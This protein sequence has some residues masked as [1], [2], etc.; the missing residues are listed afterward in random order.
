[1]TSVASPIP[2]YFFGNFEPDIVYDWRPSLVT[3]IWNDSSLTD[4]ASHLVTSGERW[5]AA[6]GTAPD[7]SWLQNDL[8]SMFQG[9]R[10]L[11]IRFLE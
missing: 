10:Q 4:G 5:R 3:D 2:G 1:M 6:A 7:E 11:V 8:L 9:S